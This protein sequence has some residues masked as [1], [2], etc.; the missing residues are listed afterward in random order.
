MSGFGR[1]SVS[2]GSCPCSRQI[3][4]I[5]LVSVV[6]LVLGKGG[7]DVLR[8]SRRIELVAY[9]LIVAIGLA[10]LGGSVY[11]IWA[12]RRRGS[13]HEDPAERRPDGAIP[14]TLVLATGATPCASA[15]IILLFALGQVCF[16][17]GWPRPW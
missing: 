16:W 14:A 17:S 5:G 8:D 12:R 1:R 15:V 13:A 7:F 10:M 11:E 3:S 4:A 2:R 6:A 9:G